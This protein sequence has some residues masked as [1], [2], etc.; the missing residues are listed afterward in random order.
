ML[1]GLA[2]K[3][4]EAGLVVLQAGYVLGEG[5]LVGCLAAGI[6]G[7]ADCRGEFTG[8]ACFLL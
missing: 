1:A 7:D 6:D 2:G 3:E 8:D 5:F 4:D